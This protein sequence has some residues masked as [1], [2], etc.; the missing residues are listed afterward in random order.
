MHALQGPG[1][2]QQHGAA[3]VSMH[4]LRG[5]YEGMPHGCSCCTAAAAAR[6]LARIAWADLPGQAA[7]QAGRRPCKQAGCAARRRLRGPI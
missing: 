6:L 5:C 1:M 3:G 4:V 7:V 2:V